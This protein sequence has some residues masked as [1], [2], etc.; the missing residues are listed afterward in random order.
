[1][2]RASHEPPPAARAKRTGFI[3]PHSSFGFMA[4]PSFRP[5]ARFKLKRAAIS[6]LQRL[7]LRRN[8]FLTSGMAHLHRERSFDFTDRMDYVRNACLELLAHEV[9]RENIPGDTAEVGV[10]KGDFAQMINLAFPDRTLHLFDTF[11]GFHAEDKAFDLERAYHDHHEDFSGTSAGLVLSKMKHPE[12]CVVHAGRFPETARGLEA[13]FVFVSL[14]ADLYLPILEGLKYFYPRLA[15]GG[16]L[17]VHDFAG[18][19]YQGVRQ[20]V[21]DYCREFSVGY[22]PLCDV[23]GSVIIAKP[24]SGGT[25]SR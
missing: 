4:S 25:A 24:P 1:M 11:S 20:A 17:F 3:V 16:A 5:G 18:S 21:L 8:L 23:G 7:L 14:D 15:P 6:L 2:M 13:S 12:N 22:V 9:Y 19:G 10:Y